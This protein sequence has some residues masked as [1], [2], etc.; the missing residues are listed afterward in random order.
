MRWIVILLL[1]AL[2]AGVWLLR[3]L[4]PLGEPRIQP[5]TS[6]DEAAKRI[7]RLS[8]ADT[9]SLAPGCP[10]SAR[11][12]GRR[13]ARAVLLLHGVTNCPLQFRRLADSLYVAGD[14]VLVP[15]IP[16]HGLA[17]RMSEDLANLTAEEAMATAAECAGIMRGL[18]DTVVVAGLSTSGVLAAWL[19]TQPGAPDRAVII[20]PALAPPMHPSWIVP[21][22]TRLGDRLP[23]R[24][25]WW[26]DKL[27]EAL[28]G[29]N[30]C[31]LRWSTR[32]MAENFRLAERVARLARSR[33]PEAR[34]VAVVTT[35]ADQAVDL[36]RV[37]ALVR[38]WRARGR[39]VH[40][41]AFLASDQVHHD[42]VDPMQVGARPQLVYP[43][44]LHL[45]RGEPVPAWQ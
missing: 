17:D 42:M 10:T 16:H 18:G 29:P 25:L 13:T 5:A 11:L 14:N 34:D 4:P 7:E 6:Y 22:L 15:R 33:A 21:W 2:A 45:M 26:D 39:D 44:L 20:A 36:E 23:N 38:A 31:Y 27:R 8:A 35:M 12:H 37:D 28:P 9:A 24:S 30:Q 3:P 43:V 19:A 40:T 32:A 41:W 1:V